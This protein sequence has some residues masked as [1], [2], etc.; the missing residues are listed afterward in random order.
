[1]I[2]PSDIVN[3]LAEYLPR[4]TSLFSET[5]DVSSVTIA[6]NILT[7]NTTT[8]HGLTVG[9]TIL[10]DSGQTPNTIASAAIEVADTSVRLTFNDEHDFTSPNTTIVSESLPC[11]GFNEAEWNTTLT[12]TAVPTTTT[13][14]VNFPSGATG[15]PTFTPGNAIGYEE[16]PLSIF[17]LQ[18]VGTT[19]TT[20]QFTVT[21]SSD[22][23]DIP[24][25]TLTGIT[26]ITTSTRVAAADNIDRADAI[27]TKYSGTGTELWAFVIFN[28]MDVSKDRH[29]LNDGVATY[30]YQD[31]MRLRLLQN[32]SVVVF[33][34]SA[35]K[36]SGATAQE[37]SYGTIFN[38]LINVLFGYGGFSKTGDGSDFVPVPV[39]HGAGRSDTAVY[40]HVYDWQ[41]PV[42]ITIENGFTYYNDTA[43]RRIEGNYGMFTTDNN[44][45][46]TLA[47]DLDP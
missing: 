37:L 4:A 32:F 18:Q 13:V 25:G 21:L 9:K 10:I 14:I 17:G 44:E 16:R 1:M 30:T 36:I 46:L 40:T 23:P 35:D 3:H 26:T 22:V 33:F 28:D 6:S 20:T 34:R 15:A 8:A 41:L 2:T 5:L 38:S 19:P 45:K 11:V 7:I 42:D 31:E 29:V 24:D 39:G 12:I 43:F 27:Y 47:F